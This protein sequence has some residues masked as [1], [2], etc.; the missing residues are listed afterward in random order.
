MLMALQAKNRFAV[1]SA[2]FYGVLSPCWSWQ[3]VVKGHGEA[4]PSVS[5]TTQI[6]A[7]SIR[8]GPSNR[9]NGKGA[10]ID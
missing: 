3:I 10:A 2:V 4:N 8:R 7:T 5:P 9:R 6:P 1:K